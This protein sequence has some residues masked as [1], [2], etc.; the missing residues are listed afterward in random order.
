MATRKT[1]TLQDSSSN[2]VEKFTQENGFVGGTD[3]AK[4]L[5]IF[6]NSSGI[7]MGAG[8]YRW[9]K[10]SKT[11]A[12]T[13]EDVSS[14]TDNLDSQINM[15]PIT[16]SVDKSFS[17]YRPLSNKDQLTTLPNGQIQI[18]AKN[19][20]DINNKIVRRTSMAILQ[21]LHNNAIN[22]GGANQSVLS[23]PLADYKGTD[24]IL[25]L[26]EEI[27]T[28]I[29]ILRETVSDE[30]DIELVENS[31][32]AMLAST[33]LCS[34]LRL[35]KAIVPNPTADAVINGYKSIGTIDGVNVIEISKAAFLNNT[36]KING[37]GTSEVTNLGDIEYIIAPIGDIGSVAYVSERGP[38]TMILPDKDKPTLVTNIH[39]D[40][41]YGGGDLFTGMVVVGY[42]NGTTAP[43]TPVVFSNKHLDKN[44]KSYTK[45]E[46]EKIKEDAVQKRMN[47][48][49]DNIKGDK[50]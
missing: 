6:V 49:K 15:T 50:K 22:A 13:A 24:G 27:Q 44:S 11:R 47:K 37:N 29:N 34:K 26:T 45:Q 33:A 43:T 9:F 10:G 1:D 38:Q 19:M 5:F 28:D 42:K 12:M 35:L 40:M 39:Y 36:F 48:A 14:A 21:M 16:V 30:Q 25:E 4:N 31:Q 2:L 20:K 41:N 17:A 7:N 32:M 23:K 18:P 46:I 3:A 8:N